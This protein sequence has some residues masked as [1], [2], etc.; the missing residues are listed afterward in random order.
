LLAELL[1]EVRAGQRATDLVDEAAC[2]LMGVNR[3]DGRCLDILEQRGRVSAG[4][5]ASEARLTSGAITAVIDRLERAGYARRV[6][7][8]D[9]R[10]RVLIEPT[11]KAYR[12]SHE[13]MGRLGELGAP[14]AATYSDEQLELLVDFQRFGRRLQEDHAEWLRAKQEDRARLEDRTEA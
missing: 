3:T 2:K 9:D 1:D 14:K 12:V 13:L 5:L 11:D 6:A 7:D 4:Q 10:R 8:P